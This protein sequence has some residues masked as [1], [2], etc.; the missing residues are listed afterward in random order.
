MHGSIRAKALPESRSIARWKSQLPTWCKKSP[1]QPAQSLR[2]PRNPRPR[3]RRPSEGRLRRL[4][5]SSQLR[6]SRLSRV[7]L[8]DLP[9]DKAPRLLLQQLNNH[10]RRPLLPHQPLRHEH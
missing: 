10:H 3:Q 2:L 9:P 6:C 7:L 4:L 8:P 5:I 1:R